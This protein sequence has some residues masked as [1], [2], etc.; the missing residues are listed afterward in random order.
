MTIDCHRLPP[1]C[2]QV[3]RGVSGATLP[4]EMWTPNRH[5]VRGGVETA[6]LSTSVDR[7]VA[8]QYAVSGSSI[9]GMVL[10]IHQGMVDRG[11]SLDWLSQVQDT[12][13]L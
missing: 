10:E 13:S 2:S 4:R 1:N 3:Y 6:F 7:S 12:I 9:C 11:A 8:L 5:N